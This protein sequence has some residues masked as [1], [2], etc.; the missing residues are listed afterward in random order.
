MKLLFL[1]DGNTCRSPMAAAIA[2]RAL[3][4]AAPAATVASAGLAAF[5]DDGP[6]PGAV[7]V[8][9]AQGLDIASHRARAL[10]TALAFSADH[11][12][13]MTLVQAA[14]LRQILPSLASRIAPL[15]SAGDIADPARGSLDAYEQCYAQLEA[16][17]LARLPEWI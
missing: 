4:D 12:Y 9:A 1:C 11:I 13:T 17:I 14:Q 15:S 16:A 7:A 10:D 6:M 2:E 5:A 8:C 3:A